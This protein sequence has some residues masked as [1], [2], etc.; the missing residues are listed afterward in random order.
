MSGFQTALKVRLLDDTA[1]A[2]A[3][4]W[5][6]L[7]PLSYLADDGL[8]FSVPI[9]YR[10]DYASVPRFPG[11]YWLTGNTAHRPAVLHDWLISERIVPRE[12][13]DDLFLEA[14]LSVGVPRWRALLMFAAV[15]GYTRIQQLFG[16][17][18]GG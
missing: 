6:L 3:G 5:A 12:A 8:L 14:M 2:G 16:G 13:A 18:R 1:N 9:G 10:T 11:A 15:R 17:G 7:A 4:Q